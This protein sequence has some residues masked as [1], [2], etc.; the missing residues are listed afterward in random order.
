MLEEA[1]VETT[2]EGAEQSSLVMLIAHLLDPLPGEP[3]V[4]LSD[5]FKERRTRTR[6][7]THSLS[8]S[9]PNTSQT[10]KQNL[11]AIKKHTCHNE[12]QHKSAHDQR[13]KEQKK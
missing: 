2:I 12:T 13:C 1:P 7:H 5:L 6:T 3:Y 8:L 10:T 9:S 11:F 4:R